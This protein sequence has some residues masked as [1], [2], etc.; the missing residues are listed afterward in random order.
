M[1]LCRFWTRAPL[2][3]F[4]RREAVLVSGVREMFTEE[5][6]PEETHV[7]PQ[8]HPSLRLH[9]LHQEL[10]PK[11]SPEQTPAHTPDCRQRGGGGAGGRGTLRMCL[12]Q[13]CARCTSFMRS[14]LQWVNRSQIPES[15]STCGDAVWGGSRWSAW[16]WFTG[17]TN[18]WKQQK[19]VLQLQL[20]KR[21]W[22]LIHESK[23]LY[24]ECLW[25]FYLYFFNT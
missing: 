4:S 8:Q 6:W 20:M 2:G 7:V 21:V 17:K 13:N 11:N 23:K 15:E 12:N 5:V 22:S 16:I 9:L 24:F 18:S 10:H 14:F 3:L 1:L 25:I 19:A